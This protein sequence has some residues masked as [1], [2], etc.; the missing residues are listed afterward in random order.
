MS[1]SVHFDV[2]PRLLYFV[3]AG[4]DWGQAALCVQ[5]LPACPCVFCLHCASLCSVVVIT[6][7][8]RRAG[9]C[10]CNVFLSDGCVQRASR[11]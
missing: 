2:V 10:V 5:C 6:R 11:D 1:C 4:F 7:L 9:G 8:W 3:T